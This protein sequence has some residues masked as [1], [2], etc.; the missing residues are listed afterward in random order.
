MPKKSSKSFTGLTDEIEK[1]VE[2]FT[3]AAKSNTILCIM[4]NKSEYRAFTSVRKELPEELANQ[5]IVRL[6]N[7]LISNKELFDCV[8]S[9]VDPANRFYKRQAKKKAQQTQEKR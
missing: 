2:K 8:F 6:I 9:V 4:C 7:T 5:H 1:A 3:A